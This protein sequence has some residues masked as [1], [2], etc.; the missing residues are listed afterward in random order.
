MQVIGVQLL[1]V[2]SIGCWSA[3]I[4]FL[5]IY[6]IGRFVHFR[7]S[8]F[9]EMKGADWCE[10]GIDHDTERLASTTEPADVIVGDIEEFKG[11]WGRQGG[12]SFLFI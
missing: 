1:A 12:I 11:A 8:D 9:E 7:F 4:A 5:Q 6:I 2:I 3:A 10:H